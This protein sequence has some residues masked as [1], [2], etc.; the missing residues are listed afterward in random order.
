M[1]V[2]I[3]GGGKLGYYLALTLLEHKHFPVII[4]DKKQI[5]AKLANELDIPIIYGDGTKIEVLESANISKMDAVISV[6]GKDEDNLI[7]C[8]LAKKMFSA[9]KTIARANNPKN[10]AV[11][12]QLGIDITVSSTDSIARLIEREV[13]TAAIK[14]LVS[15]DHG[16]STIS[17]IQIPERYRLNGIHLSEL[18]IPE[19]SVIIAISRK[20]RTII[21]R[22]S[23][24]IFSGDK[25]L[26]MSKNT[27][28]HDLKTILKLDD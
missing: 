8:Q 28:L 13:D 22:G 23:T 16:E 4:E 12:R 20:E 2:L 6:T 25:V 5:C 14:Q 24:Q 26:V 3:I 21:P 7:S 1:N 9:P 19:D 18:N 11:M 17:E 10:A 15:V 27:V